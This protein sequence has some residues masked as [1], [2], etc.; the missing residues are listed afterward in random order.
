MF[1]KNW[2]KEIFTIPNLLS[3][4]RLVLIPVYVVIYLNATQPR[5]Y[6]TAGAILAASCMTD[7]VDGFIARKCNMVSTL[8]KILDPLA[9]KVTQLT[10]T[11][12]LSLKYPVLL[13]VILLLLTKEIF[14]IIGAVILLRRGDPF[15]SSMLAGKVSTFVLFI[16]LIALVLFPDV[17]PIIVDMIALVDSVCLIYAFFT[18]YHVFFGNTGK[19]RPSPS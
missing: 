7:A 8:G 2:K 12:C 9:D 18:Y 5:E 6:I 4:F 10:L 17:N 1:I 14:Q 11:I 16:S 13:P 19:R 3:L 15:P